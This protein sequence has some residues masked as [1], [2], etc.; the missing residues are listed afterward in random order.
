MRKREAFRDGRWVQTLRNSFDPQGRLVRSLEG[1]DVR[2]LR[3][4][5]SP[6]GSR[7]CTEHLNGALFRRTVYGSDWSYREREGFLENGDVERFVFGER[8]GLRTS[9]CYLNGEPSRY[10]EVNPQGNLVYEKRADG[11]EQ[12]IEHYE[13][14]SRMLYLYPDGRRNLLQRVDGIVGY[15]SIEAPDRIA[16]AIDFFQQSRKGIKP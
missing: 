9:M 11:R 8:D 4:E 16:A 13:G 5:D 2:I 3:W 14:G 1:D 6:D 12:F 15:E 7:T 10:Q